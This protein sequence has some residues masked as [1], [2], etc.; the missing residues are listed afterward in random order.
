MRTKTIPSRRGSTSPGFTRHRDFYDRNELIYATEVR[1]AFVVHGL[2]SRRPLAPARFRHP[3]LFRSRLETMNFRSR[4]K[5]SSC[6]ASYAK[7][8]IQVLFAALFAPKFGKC[9]QT[10]TACICIAE[11]R[12]VV[13]AHNISSTAASRAHVY[14]RHV[15]MLASIDRHIIRW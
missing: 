14:A 8:I 7:K 12:A 1:V 13:V 3:A 6:R 4:R 5:I 11:P 9:I 2:E 10:W 15:S